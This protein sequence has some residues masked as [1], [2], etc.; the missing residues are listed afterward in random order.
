[1]K[2]KQLFSIVL[3][4]LFILVL[5]GIYGLLLNKYH[6]PDSI[7]TTQ[8]DITT[9]QPEELNRHNLISLTF[10]TL[11][12]TGYDY[13]RDG[14][15]TGA[16]Y[17]YILPSAMTNNNLTQRY[18][19]VLVNNISGATKLNN[20]TC[21]CKITKQDG[22]LENIASRLANDTGI[23]YSNM[24]SMLHPFLLNE[25]D[26]PKTRLGITKVFLVAS[27]LAIILYLL[28]WCRDLI[29]HIASYHKKSE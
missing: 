10:D 3:S 11:Y 29:K 24:E 8:V 13:Y 4:G 12:Y 6:I 21:N 17:Y 1:M 23:S 7:E 5:I 14:A 22:S 20:Y 18:I 27:I 25:T 2:N 19:L 9:I 16:Y 15:K 26:Y 28:L